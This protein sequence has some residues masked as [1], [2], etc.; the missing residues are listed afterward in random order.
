VRSGLRIKG[1]KV[2]A[3]VRLA[4]LRFAKWLRTRF[5]FPIRVP[6]YLSPN[7]RIRTQSGKRV[8]A[9][10][11]A[12]NDGDVEPFIR[13]ATGDY[14]LLRA[15]L[16]RDRALAS[17][18]CSFAHEIIHYQQWRSKRPTCESEAVRGAAK[19]IRLYAKT[20]GHP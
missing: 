3:E 1:R 6:V 12:P 8:P 14:A 9:C 15:K 7:E 16:G 4:A 11:F 13:V 20:V 10:F 17:I 19:L 18:L 2:S 5:Q